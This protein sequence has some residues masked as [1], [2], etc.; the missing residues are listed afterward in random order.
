MKR[1]GDGPKRRGRVEICRERETR[2]KGP[3]DT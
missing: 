3:K 2:M 1:R